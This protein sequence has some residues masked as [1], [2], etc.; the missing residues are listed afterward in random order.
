MIDLPKT[1][2]KSTKATSGQ[3]VYFKSTLT[4]AWYRKLEGRAPCVFAALYE[5]IR[6]TS[7]YPSSIGNILEI[8]IILTNWVD[9]TIANNVEITSHQLSQNGP[10]RR[11]VLYN[12]DTADRKHL[13]ILQWCSLVDILCNDASS[14]TQSLWEFG[15]LMK[16]ISFDHMFQN[17]DYMYNWTQHQCINME[18]KTS[19]QYNLTSRAIGKLVNLC[20]TTLYLYQTKRWW[21]CASLSFKHFM[22]FQP[23]KVFNI[24]EIKGAWNFNFLWHFETEDVFHLLTIS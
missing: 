21:Y 10:F 18:L 6:T 12:N 11:R 13:N 14:N 24:D 20:D 22:K 15:V 7:I 3:N 1:V 23:L 17:Y 8:T 2:L 9:Y 16:Y 5:Y 19:S 4:T